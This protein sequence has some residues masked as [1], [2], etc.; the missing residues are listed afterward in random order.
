MGQTG[1]EIEGHIRDTREELRSNLQELEVRVKSA[2]D[3]RERFR[4]NPALGLGLAVS[5]GFLL[6]MLTTRSPGRAAVRDKTDAGRSGRHGE[7][8][9]SLATIRSS[10]IAIV[11]SRAA[12]LLTARLL[13]PARRVGESAPDS[14]DLQ[15]E[16]DYRAARRYRRSAETF[17]Q[18]ADIGRA[19]RE[20]APRNPGEAEEMREAEAQG[21]SHARS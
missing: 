3:W 6:A 17:A 16:G 10:L 9:K 20:A 4:R 14:G 15:G 8:Q 7:A 19:A 12:E 5:G 21:R 2:V 1:D 18:T 11:V 13:R